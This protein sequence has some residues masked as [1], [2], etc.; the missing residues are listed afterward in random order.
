MWNNA[1]LNE[2]SLTKR[3]VRCCIN[4]PYNPERKQCKMI[5]TT[6]VLLPRIPI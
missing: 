2:K 5:P 4:V 6:T 1:F 3:Y